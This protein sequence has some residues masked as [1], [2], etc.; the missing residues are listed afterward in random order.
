MKTMLQHLKHGGQVAINDD[1]IDNVAT[2]QGYGDG[3]MAVRI[4]GS[5]LI[6]P[7]EKTTA[8]GFRRLMKWIDAEA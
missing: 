4:S 8:A 5:G 2:I 3:T 1:R 6:S 7:E